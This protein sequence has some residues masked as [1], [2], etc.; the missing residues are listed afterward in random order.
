MNLIIQYSLK[1]EKVKEGLFSII[2]NFHEQINIQEKFIYVSSTSNKIQMAE[3]I[4]SAVTN[5]FEKTIM[6]SADIIV[7]FYPFRNNTIKWQL[8]SKV[9]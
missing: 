8:I 9:C 4:I 2:K 6:G 7:V 1:D 5:Y 3:K